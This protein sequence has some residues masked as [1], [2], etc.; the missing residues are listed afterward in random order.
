ME[1]K[2]TDLA[3]EENWHYHLTK[4]A[5]FTPEKGET[6][7]CVVSHTTGTKTY[8][9]G[10]AGYVSPAQ[11]RAPP[12]DSQDSPYSPTTLLRKTQ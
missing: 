6:Y 3:F 12:D 10:R 2:Q 5:V 9:W 11:R 1:S 7:T 4:H 8:N